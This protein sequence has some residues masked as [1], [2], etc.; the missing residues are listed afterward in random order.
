MLKPA[1]ANERL[2]V[3]TLN[4]DL[5]AWQSSRHIFSSCFLLSYQ[6]Y[7]YEVKIQIH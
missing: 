4:D 1:D 3:I 6:C 2:S 5:L 7:K